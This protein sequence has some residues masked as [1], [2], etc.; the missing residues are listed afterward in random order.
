MAPLG[1]ADAEFE[2]AASI[3]AAAGH[4]AEGETEA[5]IAL[6][7]PLVSAPLPPVAA[8][9]VLGLAAWR[10]GRL[11]WALDLMC[12]C[13]ET[14]PMDGTVAE[15]L[16]SLFAQAG[17]VVESLYFAKLATALG[18]HGALGVLVPQEFPPFEAAYH[19][20]REKPKLDE[21]R[22]DLSA[23]R[24]DQAVAKARQHVAL[25]GEDVEGRAFS[26]AALLRAGRACE[27]VEDM[28]A[29]ALAAHSSAPLA[30]LYGRCLAAAGD[31]AAA[32][33]WHETAEA[34]APDDAA[35]AAAA[36]AD[37]AWLADAP[38]LAAAGADWARRFCPPARP[39]AGRRLEDKLVIAYLV[40]ALGDR[41]DAIAVGDVARAHDR[42]RV[43]V[44]AYGAGAR[45]WPENALL[46]GGFDR[47]Q[48]VGTLDGATI[49]RCL[50]RDGIHVAIDVSGFAA[51]QMLLALARTTT[52]IRVSWLG[53][54]ACLGAPVYDARIVAASAA[55]GDADWAIAGGYPVVCSRYRAARA[56]RGSLHLGADASLAQLGDETVSC[57]AAILRALPQ[58]KLLLRS[59]D[60]SAGAVDRLVARFG[61]DLAARI[62]LVASERCQDF[63]ALVD[64]ALAPY[65]GLSARIAAE[66]LACGVP[67]L[68]FPGPAAVA[69]YGAF[70]QG[71]V[72]AS[73]VA[74]DDGDCVRRALALVADG[75]AWPEAAASADATAFARAI[76]RRA[77]SVLDA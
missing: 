8:R 9:Y 1:E 31:A 68:A 21:A 70:L 67:A 41:A 17:N 12:Q 30:S 32:R 16:A 35:I 28:R 18:G 7:E 42:S 29:V 75:N 61:R 76:E 50:A 55:A 27:A 26:A 66:A 11:D 54:P 63:Y 39:R 64:I 57:W 14:D 4:I 19:A 65:R 58:A 38:T 72:G 71:C 45:S 74:A 73:L 59:R 44:I 5:A 46:S 53:N 33:R 2:I 22:I 51:P 24:L 49:A 62:D 69:P 56:V 47:W 52:A 43:K 13:H 48:D 36:I 25:D 34:L 15:T 6:L 60:T 10:M 77:F 23:G 40:P 37:G 20:I 3:R